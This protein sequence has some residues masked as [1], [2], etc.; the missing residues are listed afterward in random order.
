MLHV[1]S[2]SAL[3]QSGELFDKSCGI[4]RAS[5]LGRTCYVVLTK[6]RIALSI[7]S[8]CLR[9]TEECFE[10]YDHDK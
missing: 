10:F 9:I 1:T 4:Y 3:D 2:I 5:G 7:T 8:E 6:W